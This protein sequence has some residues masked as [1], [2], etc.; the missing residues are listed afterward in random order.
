MTGS[1]PAHEILRAALNSRIHEHTQENGNWHAGA[2]ATSYPAVL[3]P[4]AHE[5]PGSE[6]E[7]R[8]GAG[9]DWLFTEVHGRIPGCSEQDSAAAARGLM[10]CP[11][12]E[13]LRVLFSNGS[14]GVKETLAKTALT[15]SP[16]QSEHTN[17]SATVRRPF[18]P[19]GDR[20]RRI[21]LCRS[22][23]TKLFTRIAGLARTTLRR[24]APR[25]SRLALAPGRPSSKGG[26]RAGARLARGGGAQGRPGQPWCG[27]HS[28]RPITSASFNNSLALRLVAA[29][30][31]VITGQLLPAPLA[32]AGIQRSREKETGEACNGGRGV[33]ARA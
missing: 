22:N 16:G 12:G 27:L 24:L 8:V 4:H 17:S 11:G 33:G 14:G 1:L 21:D 20:A 26:L 23:G 25:R 9:I 32:R 18:S 29:R 3:A 19:R 5:I 15:P 10:P 7:F 6:H 13:S 30:P 31:N 2:L 28:S